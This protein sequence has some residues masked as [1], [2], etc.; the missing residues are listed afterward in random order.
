[1]EKWQ[2]NIIKGMKL[3]KKGCGN[4]PADS[5]SECPFCDFCEKPPFIFFFQTKEEKA[6]HERLINA[7]VSLI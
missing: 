6:K 3:I 1:M 4:S 5:C 7:P 2:E